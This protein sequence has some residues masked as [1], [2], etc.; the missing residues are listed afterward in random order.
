MIW[1]KPDRLD[2]IENPRTMQVTTADYTSCRR[3]WT[4]T[5]TEYVGSHTTDLKCQ[6]TETTPS[7]FSDHDAIKVE[8]KTYEH[9]HILRSQTTMLNIP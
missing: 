5:R 8:T 7:V 1:S 3:T 4:L 2:L 6:E 9:V